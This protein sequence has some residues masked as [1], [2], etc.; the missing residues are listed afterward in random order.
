M[1]LR[2]GSSGPGSR[3]AVRSRG[4]RLSPEAEAEAEAAAEAAAEI[5]L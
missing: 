4:G 3:K 5:H 2:T 1:A